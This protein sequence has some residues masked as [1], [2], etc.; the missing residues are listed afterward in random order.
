[1]NESIDYTVYYKRFHD[2]TDQHIADQ[3]RFFARILGPYLKGIDKDACILDFGC[4]IGLCVNALKTLGFKNVKGIDISSQQ[5]CMGQEKGFDVEFCPDT[6]SYLKNH[7]ASFDLILILD[8]IEHLP[9]DQQLAYCRAACSALKEKGRLICMVP[10]ANSALAA[11]W[12]YGDWTHQ[13]SFTE[14]SLEFLL[15]NSGFS[16]VKVEEVEFVGRPKHFWALY[17]RNVRIWWLRTIFRFMR[18]LMMY[19]ELGSEA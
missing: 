1:M 3:N 15:K 16:N 13:S 6:L 4:G 2:L 11:R 18:R 9:V 19:S 7:K 14:H 5:V 12:L 10:N 17:R 8:V